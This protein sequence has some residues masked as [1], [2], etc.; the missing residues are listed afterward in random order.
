MTLTTEP[1][2]HAG[3]VGNLSSDPELRF[4]ASG[5]AYLRAR[6]AVRPYRAKGEPPTEPVFYDLTCFGSLAEN[7]AEAGRKGDRLTVAGRIEHSTWTDAAGEEHE[8]TGIVAESIGFDMRFATVEITRPQRSSPPAAITSELV[9][10][11][12]RPEPF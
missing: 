10:A 12:S 5:V 2:H 4:S 7:V 6:I 11:S 3:L 1:L 8:Q 9:S